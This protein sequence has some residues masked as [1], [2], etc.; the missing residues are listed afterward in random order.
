MHFGR[1]GYR[2]IEVPKGQAPT[3]HEYVVVPCKEAFR[4]KESDGT[5]LYREKS[6]VAT[7]FVGCQAL[8][9][10]LVK[11]KLVRHESSGTL[12][13]A[14]D[15][16]SNDL[17][18]ATAFSQTDDTFPDLIK[19][20]SRDL[21]ADPDFR[22]LCLLKLEEKSDLRKQQTK[23]NRAFRVFPGSLTRL[24][25]QAIDLVFL[26]NEGESRAQVATKIGIGVEAL[27]DRLDQAFK[28]LEVAFPEY[29]R[30]KRR[31]RIN[32]SCDLT[33]NGLFRLSNAK[34]KAEPL[35]PDP[36]LSRL[37]IGRITSIPNRDWVRPYDEEK[38]WRASSLEREVRYQPK[39]VHIAGKDLVDI[40]QQTIPDFVADK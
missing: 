23:Q 16:F 20:L 34:F 31:P 22:W 11:A 36:E 30:Q 37:A 7:S 10:E 38:V 19:H 2:T 4:F 1:Q 17:R 32:M 15:N 24:Q 18:Y 3:K 13:R 28:K 26:E 40:Y 5:R 29:S 9:N 6:K 33:L 35:F 12:G 27:R 25:R 21:L 8:E 14:G 39:R